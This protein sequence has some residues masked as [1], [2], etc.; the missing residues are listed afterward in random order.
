M[1]R[2]DLGV[3]SARLCSVTGGPRDGLCAL[4]R[5]PSVTSL[6]VHRS[7]FFLAVRAYGTAQDLFAAADLGR[8]MGHRRGPS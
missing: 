8:C 4:W 5:T 1:E 2:S 6:V 3:T 7:V